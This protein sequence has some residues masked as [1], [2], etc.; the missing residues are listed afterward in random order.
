MIGGPLGPIWLGPGR[1][2]IV[3]LGLGLSML[4]LL[5]P[6]ILGLLAWVGSGAVLPCEGCLAKLVPTLGLAGPVGRPE[7]PLALP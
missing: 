2:S 3:S 5:L 7:E 1:R 6:A 4:V